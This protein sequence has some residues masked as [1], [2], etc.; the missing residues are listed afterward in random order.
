LAQRQTI[1]TAPSHTFCAN[2]Q[3]NPAQAPSKTL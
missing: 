3:Q 1:K 2:Y